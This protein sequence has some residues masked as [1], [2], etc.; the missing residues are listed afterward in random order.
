[1]PR[2]RQDDDADRLAE[3][4]LP[5]WTDEEFAEW[6]EQNATRERAESEQPREG[7]LPRKKN[8]D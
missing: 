8:A 3:M 4:Q 2:P 5:L 7:R 1:M 6:V